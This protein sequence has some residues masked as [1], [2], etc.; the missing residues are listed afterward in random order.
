[1]THSPG[2]ETSRFFKMTQLRRLQKG[3][4]KTTTSRPSLSCYFQPCPDDEFLHPL[5]TV[6]PP[7][8]QQV[9]KYSVQRQNAYFHL[10]SYFSST[11]ICVS[12]KKMRSV[13]E[14]RHL[15]LCCFKLVCEFL[16]ELLSSFVWRVRVHFVERGENSNISFW[17]LHVNTKG[18]DTDTDIIYRVLL[19]STAV[20]LFR[21]R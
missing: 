10:E 6:Q 18:A 16:A 13:V 20:S 2:E 15:K 12:F 14:S 11:A 8:L 1:M 17:S 21:P 7:Q 5:C 9:W 3:R 19:Y 4:A